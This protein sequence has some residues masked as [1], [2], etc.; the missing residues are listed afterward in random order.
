MILRDMSGASSGACLGHHLGYVWGINWGMSGA[1]SGHVWGMSGACLGHHLDVSG[2]SSGACLGQLFSIV[3]HTSIS[4]CPLLLSV[5]LSLCPAPAP[6]LPTAAVML[7]IT[8]LHAKAHYNI[9]CFLLGTNSSPA[10]LGSTI[11]QL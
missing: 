5:L 11:L 4:G 8:L 10:L 1:S 9:Y 7:L 6:Q 2:A 3:L